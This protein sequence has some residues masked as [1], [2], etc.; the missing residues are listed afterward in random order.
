MIFHGRS[1]SPISNPHIM[2]LISSIP[3]FLLDCLA[4]IDFF[5]IV[6]CRSSFHFSTSSLWV[7]NWLG[8]LLRRR[9]FWLNSKV[10]IEKIIAEQITS[11]TCLCIYTRRFSWNRYIIFI[12]KNTETFRLL[13][14]LNWLLIRFL[15][16]KYWL[17]LLQF[18]LVCFRK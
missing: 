4:I 18:L 6:F 12:I 10:K 11:S 15:V 14:V 3:V 1:T 2:L 17:R 5:D 13:V 9:R 16:G 8:L 7:L